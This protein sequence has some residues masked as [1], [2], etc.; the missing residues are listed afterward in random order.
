MFLED[1]SGVVQDV[2]TMKQ[3]HIISYVLN[4]SPPTSL[5]RPLP[6]LGPYTLHLSYGEPVNAN[7]YSKNLL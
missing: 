2:T 4:V 7:K 6:I 1:A 5:A 3:S